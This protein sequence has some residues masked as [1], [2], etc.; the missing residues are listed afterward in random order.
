MSETTEPP[1]EQVPPRPAEVN[2]AGT[3]LVKMK[4][5]MPTD[6][7]A[8][9]LELDAP[10]ENMSGLMGKTLGFNI[11][12]YPK[13]SWGD[14]DIY[15][16]LERTDLEPQEF[17]IFGRLIGRA[18]HGLG[19]AFDK[20]MIKVGER[21]VVELRARRSKFRGSLQEFE[22]AMTAWLRQLRAEEQKR[23][24]EASKKMIGAN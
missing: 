7:G 20:P 4:E 21:V 10:Q 2:P 12:D 16:I 5:S 13:S 8:G 15:S 6:P 3:A 9:G 14:G 11:R 19:G 23:Q 18:E 17:P 24:E 22:N 1:P